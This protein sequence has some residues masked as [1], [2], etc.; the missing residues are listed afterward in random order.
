[1]K[2]RRPL[3][4]A[5]GAVV[6]VAVALVAWWLISPLFL[7]NQVDEQ[8]PMTRNATMPAGVDRAGAEA[9]MMAASKGETKADEGMTD[10]MNAAVLVK[11]GK[12]RDA[13]S[14]HKGS[15]DAIIYR[16]ADGTHV[17]RL[18]NFSS[19][20]GPDLRVWLTSANTIS[21]GGDVLAAQYVDLGPLKGNVGNQNYDIP[22]DVDING[23][24]S[25]VIWCRA[26]SVLFSS[27]IFG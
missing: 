14:F 25:V 22:A 18:Q 24:M 8:F 21:G 16:L 2:N 3:F 17:L 1:M 20:N 13:D 26:F 27:A 19:T 7:T 4:L 11:Q 15:G 10:T 23:Q 9:T 5:V 6:V 12:F